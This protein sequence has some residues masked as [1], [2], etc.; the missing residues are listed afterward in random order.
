MPGVRGGRGKGGGV[1]RK[2][3]SVCAAVSLVM[4]VAVCGLWVS[5]Y[6]EGWGVGRT[7]YLFTEALADVPPGVI[8]ADHYRLTNL[9]ACNGRVVFRATRMTQDAGSRDAWPD[10]T[11]WGRFPPQ[12]P[13]DR[14]TRWWHALGFAFDC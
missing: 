7:R 10:H 8:P 14:P 1:R 2:L 3:F 6:A 12:D 9:A 4:C 13:M 5:S 11:G